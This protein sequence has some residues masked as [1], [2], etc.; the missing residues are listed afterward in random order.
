[1][2][3]LLLLL[4][5]APLPAPLLR[6][7]PDVG[8][9][10]EEREAIG[11]PCLAFARRSA[12]DV[13]TTSVTTKNVLTR[14]FCNGWF[15]DGGVGAGRVVWGVTVGESCV[16]AG[17]LSLHARLTDGRHHCAYFACLLAVTYADFR[18]R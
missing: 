9:D 2:L 4:L 10:G 17:T 15:S 11:R 16:W 13:Y 8:R 1:M 7:A 12:Q 3:L 14:W 6:L 5:P 18:T